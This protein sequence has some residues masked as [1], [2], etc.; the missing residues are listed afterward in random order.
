MYTCAFDHSE[1]SLDTVDG[2]ADM[3]QQRS[4][5]TQQDAQA[6]LAALAEARHRTV[7]MAEMVRERSA[8]A[9]LHAVAAGDKLR[10]ALA[11]WQSRLEKKAAAVC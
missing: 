7:A 6:F 10:A 5:T 11:A 2:A 1:H 9:Q 3:A 4:R 8:H